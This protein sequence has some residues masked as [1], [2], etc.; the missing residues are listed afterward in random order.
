MPLRF[1][2]FVWCCCL[3][4]CCAGP[5]GIFAQSRPATTH[6]DRAIQTNNLGAAYMNQQ[7][8]DKAAQLFAQAWQEDPQLIPARVNQGIA[9]LNAQKLEDAKLAFEEVLA[10][11]PNNVRAWYNLGLVS[12][13]SN[14]MQETIEDFERVVR[15]APGDADAHYFLGS[16]YLQERDYAQAAAEFQRALRINPLH[17]SA[18]FGLARA[19]QH[20]GNK[21]A[22]RED[23]GRF[24][25]ITEQ[26]LGS[27]LTP[28]YGEMGRL[29]LVLSVHTDHPEV[30]AMVPV[31]F[32]PVTI[33][34]HADDSAANGASGAGCLLD[35]EGAGEEDL[36]VLSHGEHALHVYRNLGARGFQEL[37]PGMTGLDLSG[38]AVACAVGDFDN[39]GLP[40]IAI[41]MDDRVALFKGL[42]HGKFAD[43]TKTAGIVATGRPAGLT[44]LDYDHDGDLDLFVTGRVSGANGPNVLWRNN[45][46][47]TFTDWTQQ[48]G[49]RGE[50]STRNATLSDL[51]N[52]RAVDLV[53]T[54]SGAA[55]TWFAN[56]REGPF[57][58]S[59]LYFEK[60]LPA[61][62]GVYVFDYNKDGWMDV[63][64]THD[65]APGVTLWRNV[66]GKRF[67]RVPLPV[68][69]A[70]R[71]WGLTAIDIDNDGW[72]DL[73]VL[74]E[75]AKGTQ[76]RVLRNRGPRGFED[77]TA[78][79]GLADLDLKGARSILAADM[80]RDGDADLVVTQSNGDAV[81][82]RNDGG[83]R[84]HWLRLSL[85][86]LADNRSAIGAKVE[87]F[88]G[89][90]WQK[91]EVAGAT[92]YMGQSSP[93]I[94]AGLGSQTK[95][96]IVRMVWPTGVL[97]DELNLPADKH[98]A[99][100]EIDRRGSSCPVLFA[101]D[102]KQYRFVSDVIGAAVVGH[103]VSPTAT[104]IPD[105]DEWIKV[106]GDQL[107][108]QNGFFSLRFGEP[109]EEVNFV[110]QLRL[111]AVDHPE[112]TEV[113]PNE[114]FLSTPPFPRERV[115]VSGAAR[116]V[117]AAWDDSGKDVT[118]LLLHR[119]H[120]YVRGFTNLSFAGFANRHTLTFDIGRWD[121]QRP[122][123]LLLHGY[124]EYFSASSMYAAWQAGLKPEPPTLQAQMPDGSWRT[125]LQDMGFPAGLPRTITV[126]LTGKLPPGAH[127]LRMTT[128]LQI[129]W[130]Q[131]L[132]DNG[133]DRAGEVR[134]TELPL[135]ASTLAFRGYPQQVEGKTPGDLTY[136]YDRISSTGPFARQRGEYTRYGDVTP[137][138]KKIDD[139]FV[140]FGSGEEIDAEFRA[141]ALPPLTAHWKRDYFFYANGFVKDMDFYEAAPFTVAGIPFHA[142][143]R[144][145]YSKPQHYPT[146]PE[147]VRYRLEWNTR[148]DSGRSTQRYRFHYLPTL[149]TPPLPALAHGSASTASPGT[150]A[151]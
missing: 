118:A 20:L 13:G 84:N 21:I 149:S 79:V 91:W 48:A 98:A 3:A 54:G 33:H 62:S 141:D 76:V 27:P 86:G 75:T 68:Q 38:Q 150:G 7:N 24:Q 73:A 135:A 1:R 112:G 14:R 104:N 96:D 30:T 119:D 12:R 111:V 115:V 82:L 123:R 151:N 144:Y 2:H 88:A 41:A 59:P 90:L 117:V 71:G 136:R 101:W 105:A 28:S 56:P 87:I 124:I 94:L 102:G 85:Q 131:I 134:R 65:G 8:M 9:L 110:D 69:D 70:T 92:G 6:V 127:R 121:P 142:M 140:I 97:Q 36:L 10:K 74:L 106:S 130:D 4:G 114:R 103:W 83:N 26:K 132:V 18:E 31:K 128:D 129:Y 109:M 137:L 81:M 93:D 107:R 5:I 125:V 49:L 80:D 147:A 23:L 66:Q 61:T 126:D 37:P 99:I 72:L 44:F 116:P 50:G 60:G 22:A 40:D 46:N 15:L 89:N 122:L 113:Y 100:E 11:D 45:G 58:A 32:V 35:V 16:S 42:G 55:P 78:A 19:E 148:P 52:D 29:S 108:P 53:V 146:T 39:D 95:A 133:P 51:D 63:A 43:V 143:K 57:R 47:G 139:Q 25:R 138:L 17:A 120:E 77:I 34:G 64:V 145:S 67:E